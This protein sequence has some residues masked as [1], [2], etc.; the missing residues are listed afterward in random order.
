M[1]THDQLD[2]HFLRAVELDD[3]RDRGDDRHEMM[4]ALTALGHELDVERRRHVKQAAA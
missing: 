1:T 3:D 4:H 2:R